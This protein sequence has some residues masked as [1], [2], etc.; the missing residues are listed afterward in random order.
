MTQPITFRQSHQCFVSMYDVIIRIKRVSYYSS[1]RPHQ[2]YHRCKQNNPFGKKAI[3]NFCV[4][5]VAG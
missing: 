2:L 1:C 5:R 3:L 4:P